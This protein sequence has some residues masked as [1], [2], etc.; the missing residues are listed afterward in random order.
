MSK[1][2]AITIA[3][4]VSLGTYESGVSFEM[5]RM[6]TYHNQECDRRG[7]PR[8]KILIDV[9]TGA[10]AGGMTATIL[11]QK[12]LF[13]SNR[14]QDPADNDLYLPW[15]K[16]VDIVGLLGI[17]PGDANYSIL[18]SDFIETI[19]KRYITDVYPSGLNLAPQPLHP[20]ASP[21]IM[22][23]L[24][25]SNLNGVT[26][27]LPLA[28]GG[29]MPYTRFEDSFGTRTPIDSANPAHNT[30]GF[31][32][33]IR[34]AAVAAGAFPFAFRVKDLVR[35]L[36]DYP[37]PPNCPAPIF[38]P[39]GMHFAY[40][41]GGVFQNE[42]IGMAKNL[43]DLID[44]HVNDNRFYLF[45]APGMRD[46]TK[47]PI[48]AP[49]AT[50]LATAQAVVNA[51]FN[52]ARYQDLEHIQEINN[53]VDVFDQQA[54]ALSQL[55]CAGTISMANLSPTSN[56][57]LPLLFP[58]PADRD[59]EATRLRTQFAT[60]YGAIQAKINTAAA[61]EWIDSVLLLETIAVLGPKDKM[62]V[63]AITD[64]TGDSTDDSIKGKLA[65]GA[66]Y[67]FGGFFDVAYRQHDYDLGRQSARDFVDWLNSNIPASG[68]SLGPIYTPT[69]D[70]NT[71]DPITIDSDY[72]NVDI[73]S[74]SHAQRVQV[75]NQVL[76]AA[77]NMMDDLQVGWL[78][79]QVVDYGFLNQKVNEFFGL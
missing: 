23:G 30:V 1:K 59:T 15:V 65:G 34:N 67:A 27:G 47:S 70:L 62:T 26:Y 9:I 36:S 48:T 5:L 3:G 46:D 29:N 11:A 76:S 22:L 13:Q 71:S 20:A 56:A 50:L 58:N 16:D 33:P 7:E 31:W 32:D 2:L 75:R 63:Y 12:M 19:S 40:T 57:L 21:Q 6:L 79:E 61:N 78:G 39:T 4:A 42:P 37:V 68:P 60:E 8:N 28:S 73:Q 55:V 74:I 45:I 64:D 35:D 66:M 77:K 72:N 53:R 44:R 51:I 69:P 49:T 14:L 25:V 38:A 41:D 54:I 18:S 24:A 10:S 43:V 52:Q 17:Q